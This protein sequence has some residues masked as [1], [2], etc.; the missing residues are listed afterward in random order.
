M[1]RVRL[2]HKFAH[3]INGIDLTKHAVGDVIDLLPRQA[4]LLIAEGWAERITPVEPG[5][6]LAFAREDSKQ[7]IAS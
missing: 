4:D 3:V 7:S 5:R 1:M 6:V 2:L